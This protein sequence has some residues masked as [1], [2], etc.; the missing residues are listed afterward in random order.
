MCGVGDAAVAGHGGEGEEGPDGLGVGGVGVG[1]GGVGGVEV[2]PGADLEV[3]D[4]EDAEDDLEG[5]HVRGVAQAEGA[6]L[7]TRIL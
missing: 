2:K 6:L 3:V 7:S 1:A 5:A 4:Q